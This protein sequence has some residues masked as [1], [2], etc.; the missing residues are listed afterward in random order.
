MHTKSKHIFN[1]FVFMI[2]SAVLLIVAFLGYTYAWFTYSNDDTK[3]TGSVPVV[4]VN[5]QYAGLTEG[6]NCYTFSQHDADDVIS[7]SPTLSFQS[8]STIDVY[9]RARITFNWTSLDQSLGSVYDFIN[10]D[11]ADNWYGIS[12][13][14]NSSTNDNA[15][16]QSGWLYYKNSTAVVS[17]N[18]AREILHNIT[19]SEDMPDSVKIQIFVEAVQANTQGLNKFGNN[20]PTGWPT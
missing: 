9:V 17:N 12:A 10:V 7:T 5:V 20:L 11:I 3:M 8:T 18:T 13:N 6:T 15:L 16:V 19:V 2:L 1:S 4:A 14:S